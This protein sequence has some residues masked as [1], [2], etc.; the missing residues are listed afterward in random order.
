MLLDSSVECPLLAKSGHRLTGD[1][2]AQGRALWAHYYDEDIQYYVQKRLSTIK[3]VLFE[4]SPINDIIMLEEPK[5]FSMDYDYKRELL[6]DGSTRPFKDIDTFKRVRGVVSTLRDKKKMRATPELVSFYAQRSKQGVRVRGSSQ[7]DCIRHIC[8]ALVQGVYPFSIDI[9]RYQYIVNRFAG[10]KLYVTIDQLKNAKRQPF[11]G[12]IVFNNST[13]RSLIRS[14]L[15][16]FHYKSESNYQE[17]LDL[18]IH[19][20]LSNPATMML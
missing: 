9:P 12:N 17:W 1:K 7:D 6:S 8:R 15:K 3:T 11:V 13:N 2:H 16:Q 18:L 10:M 5:R 19:R 20:G 4:K 14:V